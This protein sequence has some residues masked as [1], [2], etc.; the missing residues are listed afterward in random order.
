VTIIVMTVV[1]RT[2]TE[3]GPRDVGVVA[4]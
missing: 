4:R 3:L 2:E 1:A